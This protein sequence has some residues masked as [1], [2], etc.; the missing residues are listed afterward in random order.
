MSDIKQ[1]HL[2]YFKVEGFKNF[3]SL[4]MKNIGQFNLI[5]GDNNTGKTS[6]LEALMFDED[7]QNLNSR[8]KHAYTQ[9]NNLQGEIANEFN[10]ITFYYNKK[11]KKDSIIYS[12]KI[13]GD[14]KLQEYF[15]RDSTIDKLDS[16][17]LDLIKEKLILNIRGLKYIS[18]LDHN[19]PGFKTLQQIDF[20]HELKGKLRYSPIVFYT[21]GYANDLITFYSEN[22]QK[23][24]ENKL[25][26]INSLT[27]F[28]PE[29][30]DIEI[31]P[32]EIK[33]IS[34]ISI[35]LK[36][37]DELIP[38]PMFGE[39]ANKLFRI[40]LEIQMVKG[41]RLM[42]DEI[43][44]GVHYSRFQLFWKTII[45]SAVENNVQLF[46]TTHNL[47]CLKYF[48]E[49]LEEKDMIQYQKDARH[50]LIEKVANN[51]IKAFTY[52]FEQFESAI[53]LGNEIRGGK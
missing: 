53:D 48:K 18:I 20:Q 43:D 25:N 41:E 2:Q 42:I 4:E 11:N 14:D 50:F 26:F 35:R 33:N 36:N 32:S 3:D 7:I 23:S 31:V 52:N 44:T 6:V 27:V 34:L 13:K 22:I 16:N 24:K 21:L 51:E 46:A 12:F 17:Q 49:A 15:L 8:L 28:I 39:G 37:I 10:Y 38:L 45:K 40:L 29:I 30:E 1:K 9:R 5:A 19:N 47:E